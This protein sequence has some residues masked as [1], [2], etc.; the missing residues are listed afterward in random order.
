MEGRLESLGF[1]LAELCF[2]ILCVLGI[3]SVAAMNL[4][5]NI[6]ES[7]EGHTK[8][9]MVEVQRAVEHYA[10]EHNGLYPS[11]VEEVI[12]SLPNQHRLM[13]GFTKDDTEPSN[14]MAAGSVVYTP[15]PMCKSSTISGYGGSDRLLNYSLANK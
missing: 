5:K 2:V 1:T 3:F 10:A 6:V 9:N 15:G 14:T 11:D 4:P 7:N 8:S 12:S 13:N